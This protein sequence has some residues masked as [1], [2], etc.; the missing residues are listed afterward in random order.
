MATNTFQIV[1]IVFMVLALTLGG[2]AVFKLVNEIDYIK[3]NPCEVCAERGYI[4]IKP[5]IQEHNHPDFNLIL[6]EF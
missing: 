5:N 4:C 3:T 6:G 1:I 2:Y